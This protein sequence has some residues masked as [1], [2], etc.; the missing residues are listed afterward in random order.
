M[1][2]AGEGVRPRRSPGPRSGAEGSGPGPAASGE[3]DRKPPRGRQRALRAARGA[4]PRGVFRSRSPFRGR[5]VPR[6]ETPTSDAGG[7]DEP[8]HELKAAPRRGTA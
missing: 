6:A 8:I 2:M 7:D 1:R 4:R 5:S 3:R